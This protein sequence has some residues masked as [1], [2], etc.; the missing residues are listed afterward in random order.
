MSHIVYGSILGSIVPLYLLYRRSLHPLPRPV[1]WEWGN[2]GDHIKGRETL[3]VNGVEGEEH[4]VAGHTAKAGEMPA[5]LKQG[6]Y[7]LKRLQDGGRGLG[8]AAFYMWINRGARRDHPL[9]PFI[10]SFH[11]LYS[12][13][14]GGEAGDV[15]GG[16]IG[17]EYTSSWTIFS[18][19][20]LPLPYWI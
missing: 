19:G 15:G 20:T 5:M 13:S 3:G 17:R 12:V 10:P 18:E 9:L 14:M 7:I 2:I 8:E 4:Q 11:G 1:H 6:A 16:G